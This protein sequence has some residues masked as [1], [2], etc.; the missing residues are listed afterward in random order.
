MLDGAFREDA[1]MRIGKLA[2][3]IVAV[4][5]VVSAAFAQNNDRNPSENTPADRA[6][7]GARLDTIHLA[8]ANSYATLTQ[9]VTVTPDCA[10]RGATS[11]SRRRNVNKV[12]ITQDIPLIGEF[13]ADT[14]RQG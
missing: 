7:E 14:P 12:G 4:F 2:W 5:A 3:A 13:F 1:V 6:L 8:M 10:F 9:I 11:V